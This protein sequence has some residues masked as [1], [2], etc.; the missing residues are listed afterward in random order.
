MDRGGYAIIGLC[1]TFNNTSLWVS[2]RTISIKAGA[3]FLSPS[4]HCIF[5]GNGV[6]GTIRINII[7][8]NVSVGIH[9]TVRIQEPSPRRIIVS[10]LQVIQLGL[11]II[12]IPA[13]TEGVIGTNDVLF[14]RGR[15]RKNGYGAITPS[16]VNIRANLCVRGIVNAY[17]VAEVLGGSPTD[18]PSD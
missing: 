16:V 18:E 10:A 7:P 5:V 14:Q 1:I 2:Y 13:V 12:V 3:D 6:V 4:A 15:P 17:N 8:Q 9:I 11:G